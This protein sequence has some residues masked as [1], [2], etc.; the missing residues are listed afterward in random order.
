MAQHHEAAIKIS[1]FHEFEFFVL[2][3]FTVS[4]S[5]ISDHLKL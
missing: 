5:V 2:D 3:L 1:E 4:A